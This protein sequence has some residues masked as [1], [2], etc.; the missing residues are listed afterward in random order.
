MSSVYLGLDIGGANL[1]AYDSKGRAESVTF[2]LYREPDRLAD[3]IRTLAARMAPPQGVLVTMTA[4]LCDCFLT[5]RQGVLKI[6]SDLESIYHSGIL[7][8]WG[9]DGAFH[10]TTTIKANPALAEASNWKALGDCLANGYFQHK[11]GLVI[12][13]GSTTT[14]IL[15]VSHGKILSDSRTDLDRLQSGELVYIGVNR[16][17]LCAV[18]DSVKY[19][20]T[21]TPIMRE[22]FATTG[23]IYLTSGDIQEDP[24]DLLTANGR[25]ATRAEARH[26]LARLIGLDYEHFAEQDATSMASQMDKKVVKIIEK[27]LQKVVQRLPNQRVEQVVVSGSG[28]FLGQRIARKFV[29]E[30]SILNLETV[31]GPEQASAA[32]AV[33]LVKLAERTL[34]S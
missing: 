21:N 2:A 8:I 7:R 6:V 19:R 11:S 23:D 27:S 30:E 14:D 22:L 3:E 10:S 12:D 24:D 20:G 15:A 9:V 13:I 34:K 1:K 5:R 4:E 25:P 29:P 17:A 28:S 16:T 18:T 26:R 32:C 33:A 31:W